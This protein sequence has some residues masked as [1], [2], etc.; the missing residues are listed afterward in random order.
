MSVSLSDIQVV[1]PACKGRSEQI[2]STL[3]RQL[4][5]GYGSG[6][7]STHSIFNG[8]DVFLPIEAAWVLRPELEVVLIL[9]VPPSENAAVEKYAKTFWEYHW[10]WQRK[11]QTF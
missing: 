5:I 4:S 9:N 6:W 8:Q 3:S 11:P 7:N 2:V 1:N 10:P